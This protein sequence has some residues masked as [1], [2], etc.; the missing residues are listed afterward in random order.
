MSDDDVLVL[1]VEARCLA[2]LYGAMIFTRE[3]SVPRET[4]TQA[5]V[6][7]LTGAHA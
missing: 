1:C 6:A 5:Q 2:D 4:L 7:A 3:T